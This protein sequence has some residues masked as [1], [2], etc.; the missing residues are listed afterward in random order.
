MFGNEFQAVIPEGLCKYGDALPYEN[1]DKLVWDPSKLKEYEV[2]QYEKKS[3]SISA[4]TTTTSSTNNIVTAVTSMTTN[5]CTMSNH[6]TNEVESTYVPIDSNSSS[7]AAV[8][9]TLAATSTAASSMQISTIQLPTTPIHSLMSSTLSS[10]LSSTATTTITTPPLSRDTQKNVINRNLIL[11]IPVGNHLRDD[12]QTLFLLLQCGHNV[13]EA[14]RRRR[15]NAA[16]SSEMSQWSEEECRNFENGLRIYGKDF[17]TIQQQ[18]VKTR[19]VGELVQF[20]YLWKKTERHDVFA[21]KARLEKK[22]YSLHPGLTDYMDRFLEEQECNGNINGNS[23]GSI[24]GGGGGNSISSGHSING[25]TSYIGIRDRSTSPAVNSLLYTSYR[26]NHRNGAG[27]T[28]DLHQNIT[29]SFSENDL[30]IKHGSNV[31]NGSTSSYGNNI[32]YTSS[33]KLE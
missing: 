27:I 16:S 18:K 25:T 28:M 22:K 24:N 32:N 2:E 14:L 6:N 7:T 15:I 4:A 17:H 19:S 11:S 29:N 3:V 26:R 9:N 31:T 5:A 13:D 8:I 20:Y 1:E 12:E 10:A 33:T 21:N 23:G 30:S